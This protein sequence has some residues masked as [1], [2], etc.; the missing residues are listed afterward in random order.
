MTPKPSVPAWQTWAAVPLI[1]L[2]VVSVACIQA[3]GDFSGL[4]MALSAFVV[5]FG[6][7]LALLAAVRWQKV[8]RDVRLEARDSLER[9]LGDRKPLSIAGLDKLCTDVLP[10]WAGQIDIARSHTED[11]VTA[12]T[13]RFADIN[14]KIGDTV[15]SSRNE[16]G[17]R[18]LALL[19]EN[20]TELNSIITTLRSALAMK[21]AML[22]EVTSLSQFTDALLLMAR[23]VG[24]IAKQTNLLALNAAIEAARAGE[25]GRGFAVVADEVRKLSNLSGETGKKISTTV[26][27]VNQA[28]AATL[29][30][31]RQY[32]EQDQEMLANSEKVIEHVVGRVHSAAVD[33][34]DSSEVL[35]RETQAVGTEIA[36]VLVALQFQDRVSQVLSHVVNDMR[37]LRERIAAHD[38]QSAPGA[39]SVAI[40]AS[41]WLDELSHTYTVPEQHV[42]HRGGIPGTAVASEITF[43]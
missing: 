4:A 2:T 38:E 33:L 12:L 9:S 42:V 37:K 17:N 10:V 3:A 40:D 34:A 1:A 41:T 24:D 6:G 19:R 29:T 28:I 35:R 20:E 18:L 36:E 21:E 39:A 32:A 25:V 16:A 43:F 7:T 8:L 5:V 14:Q 15:A 30:I 23:N 31:S 26:E 22:S 13:D 27:T 11:S